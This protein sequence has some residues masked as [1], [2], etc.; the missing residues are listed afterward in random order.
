MSLDLRD[1]KPQYFKNYQQTTTGYPR[2]QN[3][4]SWITYETPENLKK[5][6]L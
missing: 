5:F 6:P 2:R 1:L 4:P 3:T